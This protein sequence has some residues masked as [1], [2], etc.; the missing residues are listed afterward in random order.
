MIRKELKERRKL[1]P[2][3]EEDPTYQTG[4][5]KAWPHWQEPGDSSINALIEAEQP[6]KLNVGKI[7]RRRCERSHT[8]TPCRA[9]SAERRYAYLACPANN[10]C[11][12]WSCSEDWLELI[13][14]TCRV[15]KGFQ[16]VYWN[17]NIVLM[18]KYRISHAPVAMCQQL[19]MRTPWCSSVNCRDDAKDV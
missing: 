18:H 11:R 1:H 5:R 16:D 10:R 2:G 4:R 12:A 13:S 19:V 15:M 14:A 17:R 9:G 3:W 7:L 8:N 6:R